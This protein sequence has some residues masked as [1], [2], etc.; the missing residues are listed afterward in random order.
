MD[1]RNLRVA[2]RPWVLVNFCLEARQRAATVL[3]LSADVGGHL[4]KV[5]EQESWM[6]L[7]V[8]GTRQ[9]EYRALEISS[10]PY[11]SLTVQQWG[12]PRDLAFRK[13]FLD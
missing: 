1:R 3:L 7:E 4:D 8:G 12:C 5:V 10:L 13:T 6:L 9:V 11:G 2:V